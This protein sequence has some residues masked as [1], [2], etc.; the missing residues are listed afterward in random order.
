VLPQTVDFGLFTDA[1]SKEEQIWRWYR[2]REKGK[3]RDPR[4]LLQKTAD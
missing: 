4:K 3:E 1:Q 2:S